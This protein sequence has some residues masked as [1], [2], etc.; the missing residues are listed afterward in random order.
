MKLKKGFT[1]FELLVSISII[2]ILVAIASVLAAMFG[3]FFWH[4]WRRP[5]LEIEF[6]NTEPFCRNP[7]IQELQKPKEQWLMGYWIRIRVRNAGRSVAKRCMAKLME[8]KDVNRKPLL[9]FDPTALQW[10]TAYPHLT[11]HPYIIYEPWMDITAQDYEYLNI[12]NTVE[13]SALFRVNAADPRA[14]G[15]IFEYGRG[16]YFLSITVLS[17]NARPLSKEYRLL[18]EG[19]YKEIKM[20]ELPTH[21]ASWRR[22]LRR[23]RQ[24]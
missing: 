2:G 3:P 13:R 20:Y 5:K 21:L 1:L 8:I 11:F 23:N 7:I 17:E 15:I 18:W 10:V 19:D 4:W 22:L 6:E 9:T 16:E 12:V 14:R 24:E